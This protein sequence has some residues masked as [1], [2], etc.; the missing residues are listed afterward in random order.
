MEEGD[1]YLCFENLGEDF[2]TF[3]CE[4]KAMFHDHCLLMLS[5][6]AT[7]SC[8][9]CKFKVKIKPDLITN[10]FVFI[11]CLEEPDIIPRPLIVRPR[12][13]GNQQKHKKKRPP[14]IKGFKKKITDDTYLI[15]PPDLP[16]V[17]VNAMGSTGFT[18]EK[19]RD[20]RIRLSDGR[21][22]MCPGRRDCT[23]L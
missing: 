5:S 13:T 6:R 16:P 8:P 11:R 1:C 4:C 19:V 7:I 20:P 22:S 2:Q 14:P 15:P 10:S 21:Y 18:R 3:P 12:R 9:Y 23:I 17:Y